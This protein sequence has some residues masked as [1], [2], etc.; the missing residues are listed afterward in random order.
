MP[1]ELPLANGFHTQFASGNA[2]LSLRLC[3]HRESVSN[4]TLTL[5]SAKGLGATIKCHCKG[6]FTSSD[7]DASAMTLRYRSEIKRMCSILYC[8]IQRLWLRHRWGITLWAIQERCC[9]NSGVAVTVCTSRSRGPRGAKAPQPPDLEA[10]VYTLRA[11]QWMLGPLFYIFSLRWAWILYFFHILL[12][13]F[14]SLLHIHI[15]FSYVHTST[16]YELNP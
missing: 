9:C 10:P 5:T 2:P 14:C 3:S 12:L 15:S 7:C 13:S 11:I 6:P 1:L 8:Y 4:L 16:F